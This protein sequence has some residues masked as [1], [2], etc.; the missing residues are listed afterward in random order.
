MKL[1][2]P[3]FWDTKFSLTAI[4]FIPITLVTLLVNAV[5]IKFTKSMKF[6][7]PIICIGNIYIGGTGKTPTSVNIA[8]ELTK[9]GKKPAIIRKFY[10]DHEDE[11]LLIRKHFKNLIINKSRVTAVEEAE[12]ENFDIAIL[13]DG[14]QDHKIKKN[15]NIIC[16]NENQFIGN[17][18]VLPS[19]PLRENL[20]SLKRAEIILINGNKNIEFENKILNVNKN[21]SIFYA[22]YKPENIDEFKNKR[23]LAVAG[24]GNPDNF[25]K[26]LIDNNLNIEKKLIFPDHYEFSKNEIK[27]I[28]DEACK[29]EYEIIMTEKDYFK[30]KNFN[31][32]K[33][34][35][36]KVSL[37]INEK[38]RLFKKITK[39][40]DQNY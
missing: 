21:L 20:S 18:F 32:E 15:L 35:Y 37:E 16:F 7:I 4:F 40:Y 10:K 3:K 33:I 22:K 29:N 23:L 1:N 14:F 6:N 36:L 13:D 30:V 38:E 26:I 8:K 2:K 39:L 24:I 11:Y 9:F 31:L 27:N 5:K 28:I 25:F 12:K 17:G 19:G 34:K